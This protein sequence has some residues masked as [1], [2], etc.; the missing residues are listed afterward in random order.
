MLPKALRSMLQQ[1]YRDFEL[2]VV[3]DGST[4]GTRDFLEGIHH[5]QVRV[6]HQ[7][8]RRLPGALNT[9]FNEAKGELLTWISSDNYCAPYFLEALVGALD[10]RPEAGLAYADFFFID[11][12]DRILKRVSVPHYSYRSLIIRNDGNAAF[13]YRKTCMDCVG[14]YDTE[15]EGAEDWDYW[16]RIAERFNFV[17]VPEA[18]YYYR[19]HPDS[20][21]NTKGE[22]VNESVIK[23]MQKTL[24]RMSGKIDLSKLYPSLLECTD[25]KRALSAAAFDFG[26]RLLRARVRLP[27]MASALL[28]MALDQD[29][30]FAPAQ[31]HLALAR[32]YEGRWEQALELLGRIINGN[33]FPLT[34]EAAQ[35]EKACRN[36]STTELES[37]P[38]VSVDKKSFELFQREAQ[39]HL[40]YS[41]TRSACASFP[42][43]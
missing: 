39:Y 24:A 13:L 15:L 35:L 11:E 23:L 10:A 19:L 38:L 2:I 29:P 18:L 31:F 6:I 32:A 21:Q 43:R 41:H 28:T 40:T 26:T 16:L 9:G 8:N 33:G 5:P 1:T 25:Q 4:D 34:A 3:N 12:Q 14:L 30:G 7:E 20:M 42:C 36:R 27:A 17:Y 37:I 22:K